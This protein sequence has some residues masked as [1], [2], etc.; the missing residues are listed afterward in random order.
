MSAEIPDPDKFPNLHKVVTKFMIHGPCGA[1]NPKCPCMID[2][3]CS[4]KFPKE[5]VAETYAGS[6]GYP[7]Y[8]RRN[9]GLCVYRSGVPLDNKYVVPYNPYLS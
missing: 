1:A 6:D 7:H 5:Y 2:G 9:T 8:R 4:K 3:Q